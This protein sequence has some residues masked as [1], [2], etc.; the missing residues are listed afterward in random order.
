MLVVVL[1]GG[2]MGLLRYLPYLLWPQHG[3]TWQETVIFIV[4]GHDDVALLL[5][6][7][8][9]LHVV[10]NVGSR[11][12]KSGI[13]VLSREVYDVEAVLQLT[14]HAG[15]LFVRFL[16]LIDGDELRDTK[17]RDIE[18]LARQ[19]EQ[20]VQTVGILLVANIAAVT[21]HE[22]VGVHE[23]VIGIEIEGL[24]R[25]FSEC[26]VGE[27]GLLLFCEFVYFA[28]NPNAEQEIHEF[29][30]LESILLEKNFE[31]AAALLLHLFL[32]LAHIKYVFIMSFCLQRYTF[33]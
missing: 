18:F 31:H 23:D 24:L 20:V 17:R 3:D 16:F 4:V 11:L 26:E 25:H 13:N 5:L 6:R 19:R 15:N 2:L 29:L 21:S 1:S 10:L 30:T 7:Q 32:F 28:C 12:N 9:K 22:D 8:H 27:L 14:H 33:F